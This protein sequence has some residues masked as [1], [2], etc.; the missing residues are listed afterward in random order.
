MFL[1]LFSGS[2]GSI[3]FPF[4]EGQV[5][6]EHQIWQLLFLFYSTKFLF[7]AK[8]CICL[9]HT[10]LLTLEI[11]YVSGPDLTKSFFLSFS[12]YFW[13]FLLYKYHQFSCNSFYHVSSILGL[14]I[15][16]ISVF[17]IHFSS[18]CLINP[19]KNTGKTTSVCSQN[20]CKYLIPY[21]H[22]LFFFIFSISTA[23]R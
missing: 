7:L 2:T 11:S 15:Q 20:I 14:H 10:S 18:S 22:C 13:P 1:A 5:V 3:P 6:A 9:L 17:P 4:Y 8:S 12:S 16:R 19:D 21:N 23:F